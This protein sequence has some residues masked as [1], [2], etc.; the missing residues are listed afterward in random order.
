MTGFMGLVGSG[1]GAG[2]AAGAGGAAAAGSG[3]AAASGLSTGGLILSAAGALTSSIGAYYSVLSSR[4]ELRSRASSFEFQAGMADLNARQAELDAAALLEAGRHQKGLVTLRYGQAR[5]E[6]RAQQGASGLQ[7]GVGSSAEVAVS[8]EAAKEMDALTI[9]RNAFRAIGASRSR[10][11][12][13][14]NQALL[15]RVSAYNAR[16][17]ATSMSPYLSAGLSLIGGAGQVSSQ[18]LY[19]QRLE[20]G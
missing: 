6:L 18:Y 9:D 20:A 4:Y 15:S 3:A 16:Q 11:V 14:R 13:F 7:R 5:G 8:L 19:Q 1:A 12:N 2:A 17:F 10:A